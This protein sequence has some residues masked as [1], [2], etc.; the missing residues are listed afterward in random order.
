M[1]YMP[2]RNIWI[3]SRVPQALQCSDCGRTSK[4]VDSHQPDQYEYSC[5]A[6]GSRKVFTLSQINAME[7]SRF[8]K[9]PAAV[10]PIISKVTH[11]VK[12]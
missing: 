1:S 10:P 5:S 7:S 6:C 3:P 8:H 9:M 12:S 2:D 4:F 11:L